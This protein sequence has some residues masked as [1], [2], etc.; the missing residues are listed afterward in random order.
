MGQLKLSKEDKKMLSKKIKRFFLFSIISVLVVCLVSFWWAILYM[1][2]QTETSVE[3]VSEIYMEEVSRQIQQKFASITNLRLNQVNGIVLRSEPGSFTYGDEMLKELKLNARIRDFSYLGLYTEEGEA[4]KI[5]F[6]S[7]EGEEYK[8]SENQIE[9]TQYDRF[10]KNII[11]YG[12]GYALA[13]DQNDKRYLMLAEAAA[14]P[15]SDGSKSIALVAGVSMDYLNEALFLEEESA[16]VYSHVIAKDGTFVIRNNGAYRN[17]YFTRLEAIVEE[18]D[19]KTADDYVQELKAAMDGG[20]TYST[21][22]IV[23]GEVRHLFCAP[24]SNYVEWYIISA[25]PSDT[26]NHMLSD[27]DSIR[28]VIMVSVAMVILITM[29]IIFLMYYRLSIQQMKELDKKERAA[30]QANRAKSEFLSSMSHDIRTPMNAIIGMTEI[31]L[32]NLQDMMRVEDCLK[33]VRLSS[34]HLLGLI[35]DVLDMSKIE[36]GK[37]TLN[38]T[39]MSLREAMDDIVNIMQ[40]QVKERGQ[41]FDIY[42]RDIISEDVCCDA[43]RLNQVMLNLLSNAVKFTPEQG[44]IDVHLWQEGSPKGEH[45]IRTHFVVEDTGIGMSEEFQKK[46]FDTFAREEANE[47]VQKTVGTGLG[48]SITKSIVDLMGGII[49]VHS[50][51]GQGSKFHVIMDLEKADVPEDEM[52]L[53][54]WNVLVVDDNEM[55]CV[56]AVANLEALGIRADWTQDGMQAVH[57]IEEHHKEHRDYHFVLID[58]KMPNMDGIQTIQEIHKRVGNEI[59]IFLISAYDW[60]ELEEQAFDTEIEGFISKP[61]FKSTL[62]A[63]LKQYVDGEQNNVEMES[64]VHDFTGKHVLLAEDIDINWEIANEIFSAVG[65]ELVWAVNGKDCVEKFKQSEVGFYDAV[66]MDVRMPVMNGYDAT[67]A[68]RALER[69]DADLPIIAMT[70][71]AFADDAQR[72]FE[73]GMNDHLTKPLDIRECM[74][75]FQKYLG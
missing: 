24:I 7:K 68:I 1:Q 29:L 38:I 16:M 52:S 13:T 51:Q 62:Y 55:L 15:L 73:S 54:N 22:A 74:R 34:K 20:E 43:V 69:A 39:P 42:I 8:A 66:L 58:W 70:A 47:K 45:F 10:L 17:N 25:M 41:F 11:E 67:K 6:Y 27:L 5:V 3:N 50:R 32:R 14:Y 12:S 72:C 9:I 60:S 35:N 61:L 26:L 48:T 33:K 59:P 37:M 63:R 64:E 21:I 65:M 19:G 36:S 44:R 46:I 71:D 49:E 18:M 53:P 57:M 56:S 75:T 23:E 4:E 40:P 30:V 28:I 31:A 2:D